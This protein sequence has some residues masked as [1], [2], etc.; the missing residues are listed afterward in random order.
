M[1]RIS[2]PPLRILGV[3]LSPLDQSGGDFLLW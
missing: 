2:N 1:G 3:V